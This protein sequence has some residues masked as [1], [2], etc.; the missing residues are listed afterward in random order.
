MHHLL[1]QT[2]KLKNGDLRNK[3]PNK[4]SLPIGKFYAS[5]RSEVSSGPDQNLRGFSVFPKL[6]GGEMG[7][8]LNIARKYILTVFS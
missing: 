5:N 8:Q 6:S 2:N 4:E 1:V 3:M 7:S